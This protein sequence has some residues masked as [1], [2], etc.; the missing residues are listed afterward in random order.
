MNSSLRKILSPGYEPCTGFS[1]PCTS[2]RWSPSSGHVPR[3][4]FGALGDLSEVRLVMV[5]LKTGSDHDN[6]LTGRN[7]SRLG[8]PRKPVTLTFR[9]PF[10][11]SKKPPP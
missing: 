1:G 9:P 2:M 4:F 7:L 10:W 8:G 5:L 6:G 11:A 3:G